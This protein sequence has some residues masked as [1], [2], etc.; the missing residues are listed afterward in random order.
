MSDDRIKVVE[1]MKPFVGE[2]QNK[3]RLLWFK[4]NEYSPPGLCDDLSVHIPLFPVNYSVNIEN[5]DIAEIDP[6]EEVVGISA[7]TPHAMSLYFAP[8][9]SCHL[10]Y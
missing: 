4:N 6:Y 3:T 2:P 1:E 9:P 7:T 8:I 10:T 5:S